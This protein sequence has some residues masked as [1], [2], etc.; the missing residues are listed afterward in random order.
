MTSQTDTTTLV[1]TPDTVKDRLNYFHDTIGLTWRE[2]ANLGD[3]KGIPA[4]TLCSVAHGAEPKHA[5]RAQ[6]GLPPISDVIYLY[7]YMPTGEAISIGAILC[8][9][10]QL[11]ISNHPARKRCFICSPWRGKR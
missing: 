7:G 10:G 9:C 3:Y 2:I 11:F 1:R 4:G 5:H 8:G 6:L